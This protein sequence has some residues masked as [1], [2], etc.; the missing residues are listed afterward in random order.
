M[1][2]I[3][4]IQAHYTDLLVGDTN[5]SH[6]CVRALRDSKVFDEIVIAAPDTER[7]KV[8]H[9]LA[10]EWGIGCHLG[11]E[12]DVVRRLVEAAEKV[13]AKEN[14]AV[15]RVLLN[16]FYLDTDLV[17]RMVDCL[18]AEKADFV[19][20]PYDFD[21]N[22][23]ADVLTLDCLRRADHLLTSPSKKHL[24]FRPW[25]YMED[26]PDLFRVVTCEDVPTYP[27]ERLR[28][29][30]DSGLFS[31]RDCGTC[32]SFSYEYISDFLHPEDIVLDI[33]CGTGEG[34]ALLSG[35]ARKVHGA[36]LSEDAIFEA[37]KSHMAPNLSFD[38]QD[39]CALTYPDGYFDGIV[40][41]NTLEHVEDDL[42]M[43]RNLHRVVKPGGTLVLETP[44]LRTRPFNFPLISS[45]VREYQKQP[46]LDLIASCGFVAERKFGMNRGQYI[47][48][49]RAREAALVVTRRPAE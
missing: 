19:I 28:E 43:L 30:R 26:H 13:G 23:G 49:E 24:R 40:C 10:D 18:V 48:W 27:P 35:K 3:A 29:I 14:D 39:G 5:P 8:Y 36:D 16:R 32:S 21:I 6:Y 2:T 17:T 42:K 15:C 22:F 4:V 25:L 31:D 1:K 7:N 12:F 34:T 9:L 41:L 44:L 46:L 11:A 38:V 37:R 47:E 45:H 33:S 20:L